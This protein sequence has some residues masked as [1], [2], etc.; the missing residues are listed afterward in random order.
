MI[1]SEVEDALD[2]SIVLLQS[3]EEVDVHPEPNVVLRMNDE[4]AVVGTPASI[5]G[6]AA[7]NQ[8]RGA[9]AS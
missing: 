2:L 1:L 7:Y 9:V 4:I 6:L 3:G 5:K 8:V